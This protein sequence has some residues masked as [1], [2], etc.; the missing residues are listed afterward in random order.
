MGDLGSSTTTSGSRIPDSV[1]RVGPAAIPVDRAR[2]SDEAVGRVG[3]PADPG[4]RVGLAF[5]GIDR[6]GR[7]ANAV[8]LA[9]SAGDL[10]GRGELVAECPVEGWQVLEINFSVAKEAVFVDTSVKAP[11]DLGAAIV[12]GETSDKTE[13]RGAAEGR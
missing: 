5:S 4:G 1:G 13:R 9:R 6:V 8:D 7:F 3:P 11:P 12:A 10:G 2:S